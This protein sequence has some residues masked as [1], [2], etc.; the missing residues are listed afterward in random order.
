MQQKLNPHGKVCRQGDRELRVGD[1]VL[2]VRNNYDRSVFN[3]DLGRIVS[4]DA[5]ENLIRIQFEAGVSCDYD[6]NALDEIVLAYAI[7]VHRSQGSEFP[8]VVL[9]LTT[10]HY[11]MLQRN[12]L[13]TAVTRARALLIVVGSKRALNRAIGNN[14]VSRR[15]T[16]LTD[17]LCSSSMETMLD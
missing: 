11:P 12:L 14:E 2:Q 13:Y 16:A 15:H 6:Q 4:F 9:P 8:V 7:S 10:Q 5:E 17:R 1:K 3:G